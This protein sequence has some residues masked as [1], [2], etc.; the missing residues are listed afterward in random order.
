MRQKKENSEGVN[1]QSNC[2]FDIDSEKL[3]FALEPQF[4]ET[5]QSTQQNLVNQ[6]DLTIVYFDLETSGFE[7]NADILQIAA[8]FEDHAFSIYVEPTKNINP[9]ASKVTGLHQNNGVLYLRGEEVNTETLKDAL[10]SFREFLNISSKLCLLVAHNATFDIG[11]LI[12]AIIRNSM[13][14]EFKKIIGFS[15]TLSIFK[16]MYPARRG[17]GLFKL[18][19]LA[20]D[21]LNQNGDFHEAM[22]D[23]QVL[24]E[25]SSIFIAPNELINSKK[26]YTE[27]LANEAKN[28]KANTIMP[29]LKILKGIVSDNMLKKIATAGIDFDMML[30]AS[31]DEENLSLVQ[32]LS[33]CNDLN[34]PRVT[35]D[36]KTLKKIEEFMKN[37]QRRNTK[38]NIN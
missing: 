36:K 23:V 10:N 5:L 9:A 32:L 31:E 38:T 34:K 12:R 21:L 1:Y 17:P 6:N 18:N 25:L 8:K 7:K 2:G 35:K 3:N 28:Q 30:S 27:C 19:K 26:S 14:E 13:I 15:D 37:Y 22:Y 11:H 4:L 29:S 24:Q 33:E 20:K 16:K